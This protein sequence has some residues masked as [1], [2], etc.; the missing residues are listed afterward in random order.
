MF[1]KEGVILRLAN[2]I[3]SRAN[4]GVIY[5]FVKKLVAN[6]EMLEV[7]GDGKQNKSYLHV[8]DCVDAFMIALEKRGIGAC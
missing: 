6:P 5:D 4:H 2:I 8:S 7:L 1:K 3:G